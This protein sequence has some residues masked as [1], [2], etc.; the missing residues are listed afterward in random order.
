MNEI[1]PVTP[2]TAPPSAS[3]KIPFAI[4]TIAFIS[5]AVAGI[6]FFINQQAR[7]QME[8]TARTEAE[9]KAAA[10]QQELNEVNAEL[11][12]F[13]AEAKAQA[14]SEAAALA[15]AA[16]NPYLRIVTP[17]G[18][19][20]VCI[21]A[22]MKIGW[23]SQN[24][25]EVTLSLMRYHT[26]GG[27]SGIALATVAVKNPYERTEQNYNWDG[28]ASWLPTLFTV[29]ESSSYA[30]RVTGTSLTPGSKGTEDVSDKYF[31]MENCDSS[32]PA[33]P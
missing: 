29:T 9:T 12:E 6:L 19:E 31:R 27:G 28:Q 16:V 4:A 10:A 21:S 1:N 20:T 23:E 25:G 5:L 22:P 11:E 18:G 24:V 15:A 3:F 14:T 30:I 8:E 33:S 32:V 2:P 17:N 7:I 26:S 13:E